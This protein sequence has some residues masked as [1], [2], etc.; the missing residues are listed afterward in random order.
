M[1]KVIFFDLDN[2]LISFNEEEFIK[3]YLN[4]LAT[5]LSKYGY[6]QDLPKHIWTG[7]M[8]MYKNDGKVT[9]E[10]V[11]W[12]YFKSIYGQKGL[13]DFPLFEKFYQTEFDKV[14]AITCKV[15]GAKELIEFAKKNFDKVVLSTNPLFPRIATEKRITWAGLN[16]T[17]FDYITSY[18]NSCFCK[19][20]TSYYLEI[21]EKL[22]ISKDEVVM[23]GNS[24]LEDFAPTKTLNIPC[25]ITKEN[26]IISDK[27]SGI[28]PYTI[29]EIIKELEKLL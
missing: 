26:R 6:N 14:S 2:T 5:N 10:Q 9:N 18:E 29:K 4:L 13:D 22:G 1:K 11:F 23:V 8:L 25:F 21:C 27:V 24:D 19:P 7:T 16:P 28:T 15:D 20:S 17:D 3:T 12:N